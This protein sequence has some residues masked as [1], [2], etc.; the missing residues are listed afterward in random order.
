MTDNKELAECKK[1][2][3]RYRWLRDKKMFR[4]IPLVEGETFNYFCRVNAGFNDV[5]LD[6]AIDKAMEEQS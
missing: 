3:E 6:K 4:D 1:D 5:G 2:A